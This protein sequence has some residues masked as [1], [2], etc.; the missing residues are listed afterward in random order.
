MFS[1]PFAGEYRLT[2][3]FDHE[4]PILEEDSNTYQLTFCGRQEIG[5]GVKGH[6]GYD[7][8]LPVGTPVL[9]VAEGIV[10]AAGT[11]PPTFCPALQRT[12]S[13]Q[14]FVEIRHPVMSGEQFSSTYVH[15]SQIDVAE[16]QAV[17]RGQQIGLSGNSGCSTEPH[18][19]FHVW[20]LTNTNAG[21]PT[22]VDPYGWQAAALDPWGA[23]PDGSHSFWLWQAGQ[24]PRLNVEP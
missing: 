20:R 7:W 8:L 18:L 10:L 6:R 3:Y 11:D 1:R 19:H 9:S 13:D 21:M 16:G 12:V 4:L 14:R 5:G 17:T 2:N 22:I 23:A 24:A 15:L